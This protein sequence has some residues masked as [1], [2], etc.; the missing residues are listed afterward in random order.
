MNQQ[1]RLE[2]VLVVGG[3][4]GGMAS[5][6]RLAEAGVAVELIDIDPDWRVYGAGVTL[7][8]M[9]LRALCDLGLTEDILRDGHCHDGVMVFDGNGNLLKDIVSPRQRPDVPAEGGILRPVLHR[10]LQARVKGLGVAVRLGIT[11]ESFT[12]SGKSVSV[13]FTDGSS[14]TYDLVIGADGLFSRMRTLIFPDAPRPRFTGQACWRA[15]FDRPVEW[16][17]SRMYLTPTLK[18]GFTPCSPGRMYMYLLEHVPTNPWRKEEDLVDLLKDLLRGFDGIVGE[19]RDRLGPQSEINYRPLESIL[20]TQAWSSGRIVLLGDA[21]H[22]TTPHLGSGAGAAVEDA[23]VLV[24]ALSRSPTVEVAL[25]EY[26][27]QRIER[28]SLVVN[29]SLRLGEMEMAG[30]PLPEQAA[31]LDDS[32]RHIS[33]PYN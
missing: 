1:P 6:I 17:K 19:F 8:V 11:V 33:E 13:I 3:G 23:I 4:I 21:V 9:T 29:N 7:S 20:L 16:E 18:V 15:N 24:D 32:I 2:R 31:L 14:G 26:Y 5:A 25:E 30:D 22:A 10:I 28:A 27:A 12:Q